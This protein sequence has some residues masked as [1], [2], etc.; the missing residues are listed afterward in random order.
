AE[1]EDTFAVLTA[2]TRTR[3]P[4]KE[5]QRATPE[6]IQQALAF[7]ENAH[8]IGALD[9][10]RG[11]SDAAALLKDGRNPHLIHVGSGIAAM[12]EQRQD[13]LVKRIP[14]DVR[15]IGIGV[16]RRWNRNL[17]KSAAEK[18]GGLFTQINPDEAISWKAFELSNI[19]N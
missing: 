6:N 1:P 10:G 14:D 13:V 16:G 17:M 5:R 4:M 18:S 3:S 12:G 19:L 9:L 2:G 11:L 7:L 8:L 15:Y